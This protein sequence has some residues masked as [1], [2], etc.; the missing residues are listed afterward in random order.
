MNNLRHGLQVSRV[1]SKEVMRDFVFDSQRLGWIL[2]KMDD[3]LYWIAGPEGKGVYVGE[4]NHQK[5]TGIAMIQ[6][7]DTYGRVSMYFCVEEHCGK[8]FA[9]KTWKTARAAI[10]PKVS[11]SLESI[12]STVHLYEREGFKSAWKLSLYN[13][14]VPSILEACD[15]ITAH[16]SVS[17][18]IKSATEVD[19]AKLKLYTEDVI[20]FKFDRAELLEKW[21]TLPTHTALAAVNDNG[22]VVGFATIRETINLKED[23]YHLGPLLADNGDIARFLLLKL[24]KGVDSTQNLVFRVIIIPEINTEALKIANEVK[25]DHNVG[26]IYVRMYTGDE[27]P[28]KKEKYFGLFSFLT[29]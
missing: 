29:G 11:L 21:I 24:A 22:D 25:G 18:T 2:G 4:L 12:V 9:F 23:G 17:V 13:F 27:L 7:N 19:F 26:A 14:Y 16:N 1:I 8:G 10:D 28:V 20:G 6:Y 15:S 5:V 3:E